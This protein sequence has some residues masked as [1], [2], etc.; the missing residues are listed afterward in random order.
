[1]EI[2][3]GVAISRVHIVDETLGRVASFR[4]MGIGSCSDDIPIVDCHLRLRA[5]RYL[6]LAA[7]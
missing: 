2:V 6:Y 5:D 4:G 3:D 1:M 7:W